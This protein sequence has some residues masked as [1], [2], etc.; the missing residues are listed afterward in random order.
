[1]L[2]NT[3]FYIFGFGLGIFMLFNSV[4]ALYRYFHG[5]RM[6]EPFEWMFSSIV[7]FLT[8][9]VLTIWTY[10]LIKKKRSSRTRE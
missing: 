1:M 10:L 9:A 2:R 7:T 3:L 6:L 8:G 4:I 5:F